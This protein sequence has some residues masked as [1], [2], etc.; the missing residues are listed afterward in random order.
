M[1]DLVI[2]KEYLYTIENFVKSFA[3]II[4]TGHMLSVKLVPSETP[5]MK[6][7]LQVIFINLELVFMIIFI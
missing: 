3:L 1:T 5:L 2:E 4:L 7:I 6:T